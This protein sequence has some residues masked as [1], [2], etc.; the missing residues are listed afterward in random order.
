MTS[1]TIDS[2]K[3]NRSIKEA[4]NFNNKIVHIKNPIAVN[5]EDKNVSIKT[6]QSYPNDIHSD[7]TITD[8]NK[9]PNEMP[10]S[11]VLLRGLYGAAACGAYLRI[12]RTLFNQPLP[13]KDLVKVTSSCGIRAIAMGTVTKGIR[14]LYKKLNSTETT[15]LKDAGEVG[16]ITAVETAAAYVQDKTTAKDV[17][18]L[19]VLGLSFLKSIPNNA[20]DTKTYQDWTKSGLLADEEK[21][22]FVM[23]TLAAFATSIPATFLN[24][25]PLTP[26]NFT[27]TVGL[28][29]L[30]VNLWRKAM[31]LANQHGADGKKNNDNIP[32]A[33]ET[34]SINTQRKTVSPEET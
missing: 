12:Q 9:K 33:A 7:E 31:T 27:K 17:L 4:A 29:W 6:E 5:A 34:Q 11:E 14:E 28:R 15:L 19:N 3:Q 26:I 25:E 10:W 1:V 18:P 16:I 22:N 20:M 30:S 21:T 23:N 24:N 13:I 2:P 32:K 8:P